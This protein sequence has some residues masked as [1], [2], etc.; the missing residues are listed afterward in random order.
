MG[1]VGKGKETTYVV[2]LAAVAEFHD[3]GKFGSRVEHFLE[4]AN[5]GVIHDFH[6]VYL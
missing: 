4:L 5:M 6:N 3:E 1:E 2:Q